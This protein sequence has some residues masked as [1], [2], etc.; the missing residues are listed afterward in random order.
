MI[1]LTR[2]TRRTTARGLI[3]LLSG[4]WLLAAAA[5]CVM[6]A[7]HCPDMDHV[8]CGPMDHAAT[9]SDCDSLH[10]IDCQRESIA[11]SDRQP[12]PDLQFVSFLL[13]AVPQAVDASAHALLAGNVD[14]LMLRLSPPPLYLQHAALLL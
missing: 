8:S 2:Q 7:P 11:L 10:A 1:G 14:R 12:A 13:S 5:P 3:A 6:A 9:T 4:L